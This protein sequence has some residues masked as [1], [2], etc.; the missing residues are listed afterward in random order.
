MKVIKNP[1][2][3]HL[4][5]GIKKVGTSSKGPLININ[6]YVKTLGV[7]NK[8]I[9]FVIGAVSIGNPGME[10]EYIDE[11]VSISSYGLSGAC[12][13]SKICFAFEGLWNVL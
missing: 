2:I 10:A 11:C 8:P 1:V 4:P 5:L 9:C 3:D 6:D 7:Q 12:V 13:C